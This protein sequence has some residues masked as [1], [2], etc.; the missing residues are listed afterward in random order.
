MQIKLFKRLLQRIYYIRY[1]C[2]ICVQRGSKTEIK[3]T[4][5]QVETRK[6]FSH[7][8]FF[9]E[10][11]GV[12]L[13]YDVYSCRAI[14]R[15]PYSYCVVRRAPAFTKSRLSPREKQ[16]ITRSFIQRGGTYIRINKS[17]YICIISVYR[18]LFSVGSLLAVKKKIHPRRPVRPLPPRRRFRR[19]L[20]A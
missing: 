10:I 9:F 15:S 18:Y 2:N 17:T 7:L 3:A 4:K 19:P 13:R 1:A 12:L 8:V 6:N 5:I 14:R 20:H 11:Q 16:P